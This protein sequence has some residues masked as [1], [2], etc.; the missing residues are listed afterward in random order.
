[1]KFTLSTFSWIKWTPLLGAASFFL[2]SSVFAEKPESITS[3][4]KADTLNDQQIN[5]FSAKGRWLGPQWWANRLQDWSRT[6]TTGQTILCAPTHPFSSWRV[7]HDM[8]HPLDL[9]QGNLDVSVQVS[10]LPE[11]KGAP[12]APDSLA[13]L[14]IGTGN[15]LKDPM[16]RMMVFEFRKNKNS[17]TPYAKVIGS[18]IAVG[19]S[20]DGHLRMIDLDQGNAVAET[21][22]QPSTTLSKLPLHIT[23]QQ[24][25]NKVQLTAVSGSAKIS[26]D[27]PASRFQGGIALTSHPGTK[28]KKLT[29]LISQ[30]NQYSLK[31]GFSTTNDNAVGP[32]V[33][34]QYT[35]D[36]GVLKLSAQCMPQPKGTQATI[37]FYRNGN[38]KQAAE[39]TVH[40]IDQ[41]ALFRIEN[42]DSSQAIPY[43]VSIPLAGSSQPA[44]FTGT[45]TAQPNNGKLRLALLG[46]I[47]HRPW[48]NVT[49]WNEA[50]DFPHHDI[51]KRV[52][53][54]KP[55]AAFFYGD[56][57]YESTPSGVDR[58]DYFND[59]LY[60][61]IF[62]CVSFRETLRN[63]PTVTVPDDHDVFQGNYWGEGGR[64]APHN[65]WNYGGY[66][67]PAEFVAQ[68]HRT[69]T[70]HL[71][72]PADPHCLKQNLP[73]YHCD[74]NW[75]GVSFAILGDRYFKS[76]P[77]GHGLPK[78]GTNRP[79]HYNNPDFNT[80]D[81][82]LPGLQL[83]GEPQEKFLAHWAADW[84]DNSQIKAVLS[85]SPFGNLATHHSGT[86]LI[87]DLDSNGWP[88]S[89][90]NRALEIMRAARSV[91][92]VGDQHLAT[93]VQHGIKDYGDAVFSF[94]GPSVANAYARAYYP[95]NKDNYYKSPPPKPKDY[96]GNHLDGFKNKVTF[97]AVANPD[98]TKNS[99]YRT[100]TRARTNMQVPG[101]G[102]I[103]FDIKDHT[104]TFDCKPR[105]EEVAKRL[106]GGS[107]PG[108][109]LTVKTIQND[110]RKPVGE[111]ASISVKGEQRPVVRVYGPDGKLEWAQRMDSLTFSVPAY[112][113]G[114]H[115]V[116]IG[117]GEKGKWHTIDNLTPQK[118]TTP[119]EIKLP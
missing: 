50:L 114:K 46:G 45:I 86:Y 70:S 34:A 85:Q 23:T 4:V 28:S 68:V 3:L 102:I 78:S 115:R 37:A 26:A 119:V 69:Q 21:K 82:D 63:I 97:Y 14:L 43:R 108:W 71:P 111:L 96:L 81:L 5:G 24:K 15:T 47:M 104:V 89:G 33:A 92:I 51:Q 30:F 9:T 110:G 91:H 77:A 88:Q 93:L 94:A 116:E 39:A 40:P 8:T 109:P 95:A 36:R 29:S 11:V 58:K 53:A 66:L 38:W 19:I 101:Y 6:G 62:H 2:I 118:K 76:G 98:T 64:K 54:D 31:S 113:P 12:L 106:K 52:L 84:S 48:G 18:G 56:Q 60:K 100:E 10:L 87:A 72:D 65:D 22:L 117:T 25:G 99:P 13:G 61:W 44:H 107:Y 16:A 80:K 32:I 59:Y 103:D 105:S 1:M 83:L 27:F 90:R 112:L 49:H 17:K 7:A 75:G 74:W 79:D 42:W 57:I 73:A 35:V 20:G 67:H 55:D 41:L